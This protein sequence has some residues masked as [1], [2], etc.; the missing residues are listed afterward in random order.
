MKE[1]AISPF[2]I[3]FTHG[4]YVAAVVEESL[5]PGFCSDNRPDQVQ[6]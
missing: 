6:V 4:F 2:S 1:A 5:M 3:S